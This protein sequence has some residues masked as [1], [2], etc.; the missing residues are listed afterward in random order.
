MK[1][2][3]SLLVIFFHY[4]SS[5]ALIEIYDKFYS[6]NTTSA[7]FTSEDIYSFPWNTNVCFYT[8]TTN[9]VRKKHNSGWCSLCSQFL[10]GI[11]YHV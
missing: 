5:E 10:R 6:F 7:N 9:I 3:L 1:R 2:S 11:Q 8:F 4:V